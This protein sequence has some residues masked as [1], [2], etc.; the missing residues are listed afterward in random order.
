MVPMGGLG[1]ARSGGPVSQPGALGCSGRG[2]QGNC[3]LAHRAVTFGSEALGRGEGCM[4]SGIGA[5]QGLAGIC[6]GPGL[7]S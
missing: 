5:Q 6:E 1:R 3:S 2:E 7:A 4:G